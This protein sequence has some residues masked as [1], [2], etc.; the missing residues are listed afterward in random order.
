MAQGIGSEIEKL[1]NTIWL[2]QAGFGRL[3]GVTAMAVSRWK[4]GV[5]AVPSRALLALGLLARKAEMDGWAFWELGGL[6][7]AGARAMVRRT[8]ARPAAASRR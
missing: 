8:P 3:L 1:R 5:N 4:R 7:R 6:T 2:N